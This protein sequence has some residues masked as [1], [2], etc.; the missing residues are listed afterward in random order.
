MLEKLGIVGVVGILVTVGGLGVI[1]YESP[2]IA[3][4]LL[5]VLLGLGLGVFAI[6]KNTLSS[7][8]MGA[9]V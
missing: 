5:L 3:A 2:V 6:V 7:L 4:G 9:M 1:A 8:G